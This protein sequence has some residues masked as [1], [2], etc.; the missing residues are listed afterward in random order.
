MS[1]VQLSRFAGP[2]R[3]LV[4][5]L[6][7]SG[8]HA[9]QWQRLAN[10]LGDTFEFIAPEHY[11]CA[12]VGPW[13]GQHAFTLADE[14][15]RTIK[16]IDM[17]DRKIHL[18]GHSY[19]GG[20]ALHVALARP[21]RVASLSLYE[22]SAFHLLAQSQLGERALE[23]I[24]ETALAIARDI[25]AGDN[26]AAAKT[27]ID[28]WNGKGSFEALR[29]SMR[30]ALA[31]WMLTAPLNFNALFAETTP[32]AN[33]WSLRAPVLAM[34]GERAPAPTRIVSGMIPSLFP[35]A[36]LKVVPR[37]GHM[38]PLTHP[39]E[40]NALVVEHIA[41]AKSAMKRAA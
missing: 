18:V 10:A 17:T 20:V 29:P 11:G 41:A 13:T 1:I 27:F 5:A 14:A 19:G 39:A 28:Y 33:Y 37:A 36:D 21:E 9:G 3:D 35:R 25:V 40:V 38:G 31:G 12:D 24:R 26:H 22:P 16:L 4:I 32:A 2:D 23:E 34:R 8:A 15:V 6:H 30:D 7:C